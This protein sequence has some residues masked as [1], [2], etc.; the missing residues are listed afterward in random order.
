M[1][2]SKIKVNSLIKFLNLRCYWYVAVTTFYFKLTINLWLVALWIY[3]VCASSISCCIYI[4]SKIPWKYI[5]WI[6]WMQISFVCNYFSIKSK[7]IGTKWNFAANRVPCK[8]LIQEG[9][10]FFHS[11]RAI[12]GS[13]S[14]YVVNN[15]S[16]PVTV[17][18]NVEH[19]WSYLTFSCGTGS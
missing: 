12:M 2:P 9:F 14:N 16:C 13:V 10:C 19:D 5:R 8:A 15:A 11:C 1:I 7:A 17:V 3:L 18:K 4:I 6:L